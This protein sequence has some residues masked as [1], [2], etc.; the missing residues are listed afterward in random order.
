MDGGSAWAVGTG[1]GH[2]RS[3]AVAVQAPRALVRIHPG[4]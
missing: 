1:S 2:S 3:E 4:A